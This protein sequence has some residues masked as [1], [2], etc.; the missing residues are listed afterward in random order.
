MIY[1]CIII[2][3]GA[4]GCFAA[5]NIKN[6]S[7]DSN[8][9]MV[10]KT[11]KMLSKV[12]ISGGG[13]CNV[14]H[15]FVDVNS[16]A[17][18]YPRGERFMRKILHHFK[19]SDTLQWFE[20]RGV[21]LKTEADG[22]VFPVS[23]RSQDIINCLMHSMKDVEIKMNTPVETIE[24]SGDLWNV[25]IKND[26]NYLS[27]NVLIAS[28]GSPNFQNYDWIKKLGIN[29]QVTVPSLFSFNMKP[30]VLIDLMGIS[31]K[32]IRIKV[33]G[34]KLIGEGPAVITH[35]GMSGP[36]ILR[37][38]AFGAFELAERKYQFDIT[39][40][41]LPEFS[42]EELLTK[43][44]AF[45]SEHP[46]KKLQSRPFLDL[47]ERLWLK[48]LSFSEIDAQQNWNAIGLGS[49]KRI[50][51]N[52]NSFQ[53]SI[54]GKTTYKEEFVTAGGVDLT[55]INHK[56]C[57][58]QKLSGIFFAG[59]LLNTDGVTGGFNFQHAW[60]TGFIAAQEIA[61]RLTFPKVLNFWKV[62]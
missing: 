32:N 13:R 20:S 23:D 38:S 52:L 17:A 33:N 56:T 39:L 11:G 41:W 6:M 18:N 58:S 24:K 43:L 51:R 35:W 48:L 28:G 42:E 22:R 36:A 45:Q 50:A 14:T 60:T 27:K 54:N 30:H 10:E 44:L 34:T 9:L 53:L 59:E 37:L 61:N 15:H 25:K 2:G 47:A 62:R 57:E 12:L 7:P 40:N 1:D 46:R 5:A 29:I 19:P 31:L 21:K 55:E 49:I 4:A 26:T 8:V 16:F 3:G